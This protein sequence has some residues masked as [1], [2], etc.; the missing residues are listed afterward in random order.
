MFTC[1]WLLGTFKIN[2]LFPNSPP[3]HTILTF[4]GNLSYQGYEVNEVSFWKPSNP[5]KKK[6]FLYLGHSEKTSGRVHWSVRALKT[7]LSCL[8]KPHATSHADGP[9]TERPP[10]L[11]SSRGITCA[12]AKMNS[13]TSRAQLLRKTARSIM[14]QRR[15]LHDTLA[16]EK[17]TQF[18]RGRWERT[19]PLPYP[20]VSNTHRNLWREMWTA[21]KTF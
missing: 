8:E 4:I 11:L 13:L 14:T 1:V 20:R 5:R 3:P 16:E 17:H 2:L 10:S 18:Q 15:C 6:Y 19:T 7:S 12:G 21:A 9:I